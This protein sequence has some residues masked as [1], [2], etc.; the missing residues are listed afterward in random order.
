MAKVNYLFEFRQD[1]TN[2]RFFKNQKNSD[3]KK[4]ELLQDEDFAENIEDD[5]EKLLEGS[6]SYSKGLAVMF[7]DVGGG[8]AYD[9]WDGAVFKD[10]SEDEFNAIKAKHIEAFD[11]GNDELGYGGL[12]YYKG[13]IKEGT[14]IHMSTRSGIVTDD[15]T[16]PKQVID[17]G[18]VYFESVKTTFKYVPTFESFMSSQKLT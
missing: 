11:S 1:Y 3:A 6:V 16:Q 14:K 9:L 17:A 4:E 10:M 8:E 15:G 7:G 18:D 12:I 13:A 2:I 5:V